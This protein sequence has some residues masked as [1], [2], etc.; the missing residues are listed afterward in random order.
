MGLG[1]RRVS[2]SAPKSKAGVRACASLRVDKDRDGRVDRNFDSSRKKRN[3]SKAKV[4]PS[5][6]PII[7]CRLPK[8]PKKK[9]SEPG[10]MFFPTFFFFFSRTVDFPIKRLTFVYP[11]QQVNGGIIHVVELFY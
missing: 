6:R 7:S 5:P 4:P 2:Q 3:F 10:S 1:R 8:N 9:E 11:S